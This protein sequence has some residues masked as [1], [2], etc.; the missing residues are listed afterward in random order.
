MFKFYD[1]KDCQL[2]NETILKSQQG[3]QSEG[4][5]VYTKELNKIALSCNDD[6]RLETFDGIKHILTEQVLGNYVKQSY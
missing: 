4:H 5:D 2:N 1:H 6:K 3:F